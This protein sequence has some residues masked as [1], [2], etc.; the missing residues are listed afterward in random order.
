MSE[1]TALK[2]KKIATEL[3]PEEEK[4]KQEDEEAK[5]ENNESS[6]TSTTF[7]QQQYNVGEFVYVE[8]EPGKQVSYSLLD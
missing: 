8:T 1:V 2:S 4:I 5:A 7:N 6:T 3:P